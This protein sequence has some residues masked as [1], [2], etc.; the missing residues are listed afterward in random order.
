VEEARASRMDEWI[1]WKA[2]GDVANSLFLLFLAHSARRMS[3]IGAHR[4]RVSFVSGHISL[5][6]EWRCLEIKIKSNQIR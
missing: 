5:R 4:P 1:I 6:D 3:F 2:E